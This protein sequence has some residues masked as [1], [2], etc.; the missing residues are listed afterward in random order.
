MPVIDVNNP[1]FRTKVLTA[2]PEELRLMLLEGSLR[3]MR[4]AREGMG[5]RD[6][7]RMFE[8]ISSARN[9]VVELMTSLRHDIAPDLCARMD[10]LYNYMF[11]RLTEASFEKDASKL[12]EV[13]SLM[14]YERET[15]TM[16]IEKAAR[17]RGNA[18]SAPPGAV[19]GAPAPEAPS[20]G[21]QRAP[22]SVQG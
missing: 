14:D 2:R 20:R 9:I 15:W 7:E 3:F 18:P 1:Y 5:A 16:V 22:L 4:D 21:A 11:R 10:S 12:D 17:E 8:G 13:I 19:A 6:Y